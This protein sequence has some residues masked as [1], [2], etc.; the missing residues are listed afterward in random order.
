MTSYID[1][2]KIGGLE[3]CCWSEKE[4]RQ[5]TASIPPIFILH[6]DNIPPIL[7][8]SIYQ[9]RIYCRIQRKRSETDIFQSTSV[10]VTSMKKTRELFAE[11]HR[12]FAFASLIEDRCGQWASADGAV[13]NDLEP[14]RP[15]CAGEPGSFPIDAKSADITLKGVELLTAATRPALDRLL[16]DLCRSF[17]SRR[18]RRRGAAR[19]G[20][21]ENQRKRGQPP[22]FSH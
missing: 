9:C 19:C 12:A 3:E 5:I 17:G 22:G 6:S 1:R 10:E 16:S 2:L 13:D 8:S 20:Q 11:V 21:R 18:S 4:D 15:R 14:A 7:Q